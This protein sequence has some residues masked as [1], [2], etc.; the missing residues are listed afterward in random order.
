MPVFVFKNMCWWAI[1]APHRR[2]GLPLMADDPTRKAMCRVGLSGSRDRA[3]PHDQLQRSHGTTET[4]HPLKRATKSGFLVRTGL[5][6]RVQQRSGGED[7]NGE[8]R[9][10]SQPRNHGHPTTATSPRPRTPPAPD[11]DGTH[12]F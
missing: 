3:P 7:R 11:R 10:P 9:T 2:G 6:P 8:A 12:I 4:Q 1:T 5:R